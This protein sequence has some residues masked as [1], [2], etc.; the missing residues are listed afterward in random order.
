MMSMQEVRRTARTS[1]TVYVAGRG[2]DLEVV[3][4]G[5]QVADE[6]PEEQR[7]GGHHDEVQQREAADLADL[8]GS[9]RTDPMP[10]T[11]VQ[12]MIGPIIILIRLTNIVPRTPICSNRGASRPTSHP[13]DHRR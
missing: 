4:G 12:K 11:I 2:R 13:G 7:E 3:T 8:R 5:D 9:L 10:S 6:Q 1:G